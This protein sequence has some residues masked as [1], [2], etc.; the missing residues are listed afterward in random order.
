MRRGSMGAVRGRGPIETKLPCPVCLIMMDKAQVKGRAGVLT[1]DHCSRCG[2]VWFE[3]GEVQ[4]LAMSQPAA[5]W[6]E[7]APR[8]DLPKPLCHHCQS[9]I[10]RDAPKC[11]ACGKPNVLNCPSCDQTMRRHEVNGLVLDVCERCHGVW[12]DNR[13]LSAVW[14]LSV[15]A[16]QRRRSSG[17]GEA[18][19]IGGDV[20]LNT[21]FWAPGLVVEGA[22]GA[23]HLGGAAIEVAGGA[24][25]GVFEAIL[26]FISSLFDG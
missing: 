15:E 4:A 13:E 25:E 7:V 26:G 3:R 12:F 8:A 14:R 2:G 24:A 21:M 9:P 19:A 16:M 6:T 23:A 11:G 10:D 17:L 22:I 1:L 18:A 20:L 5:L